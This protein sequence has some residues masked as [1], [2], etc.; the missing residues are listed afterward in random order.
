[1]GNKYVIVV[2]GHIV[3]TFIEG[4][5]REHITAKFQL[6]AENMTLGRCRERVLQLDPQVVIASLGKALS[7]RLPFEWEQEWKVVVDYTKLNSKKTEQKVVKY[8][9]ATINNHKVVVFN[10]PANRHAYGNFN[11]K[12]GKCECDNI[13]IE[14]RKIVKK[15]LRLF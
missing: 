2:S 10:S 7:V 13:G 12:D 4:W 15:E 14:M 8:N 5:T 11:F 6:A 9:I 1:L 3:Y